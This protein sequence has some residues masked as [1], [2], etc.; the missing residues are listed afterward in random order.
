MRFPGHNLPLRRLVTSSLTR[1]IL[2]ASRCCLILPAHAQNIG[3]ADLSTAPKACRI[4][5]RN[6][7]D[8]STTRPCPAKAGLVLLV[9]EDDLRNRLRRPHPQSRSARTGG[10]DLVRAVRFDHRHD[11]TADS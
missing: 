11:R 9:S 6:N 1:V 2:L 4:V 5:D 8:D 3:S 10:A 7:V